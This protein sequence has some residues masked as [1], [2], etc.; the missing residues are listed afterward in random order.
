[1]VEAGLCFTAKQ[2]EERLNLK[3]ASVLTVDIMQIDTN[4]ETEEAKD[5]HGYQCEHSLFIS[6]EKYYTE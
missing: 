4:R 5:S 3:P 6:Q 1:M 2:N